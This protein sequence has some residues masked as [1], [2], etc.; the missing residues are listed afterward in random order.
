MYRDEL[1][2][3]EFY[4]KDFDFSYSSI[5]TLLYQPKLFYNSYV[6]GKRESKES[7]SIIEG[8]LIHLL[9]LE[10]VN[11]EKK[12][13]VAAN[14]VPGV[15][16]KSIIDKIYYTHKNDK[17]GIKEL[18]DYRDEILEIL[19][20]NNLY[21]KLVDDKKTSLTGDDKRFNKVVD[22]VSTEYFNYLVS[23]AGKEIISNE[24]YTK[25]KNAVEEMLSQEWLKKILG[26]SNL[27]LDKHNEKKLKCKLDD[28]NFGLKGIIDNF[29]IDNEYKIITINDVKTTS[30]ELINFKES[31]DYYDYW[32]Q[33]VIYKILVEKNYGKEYRID[34]NFIVVDKYNT[35]YPFPVSIETF[36]EWT[37]RFE[38]EVLKKVS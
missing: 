12:Y 7:P 31:I 33:A 27:N 2:E 1:K 25:C 11:F 38:N 36:K 6:L 29:V 13:V 15:S 26:L 10:P 21:Q 22:N 16:I 23:S 24:L 9:M 18:K 14:S 35:V 30:K 37:E 28:Y 5:N 4:A 3:A 32:M 8:R 20:E 34:F 19:V 17:E